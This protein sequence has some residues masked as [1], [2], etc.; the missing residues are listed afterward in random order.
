MGISSIKYEIVMK[1]N[2]TWLAA[3]FVK[4]SVAVLKHHNQNQPGAERVYFSL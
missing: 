4:V 1:V 3:V 2:L